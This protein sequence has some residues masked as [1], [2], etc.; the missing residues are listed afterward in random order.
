MHIAIMHMFYGWLAES[1]RCGLVPHPP[2]AH[3]IARTAVAATRP[4]HGEA[5]F[6]VNTAV[7]MAQV[8][9]HTLSHVR[10]YTAHYGT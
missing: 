8:A 7:S 6:N 1:A 10:Y 5:A 9:P 4:Q 2:A 3:A